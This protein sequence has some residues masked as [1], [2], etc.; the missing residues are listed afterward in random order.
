MN[1]ENLSV[2]IDGQAPE[3]PIEII[4]REGVA[5]EVVNP[6]GFSTIATIE[7]PNEYYQ[8]KKEK[9]D[10]DKAIITYSYENQQIT[11]HENPNMN[12]DVIVGKLKINPDLLAFGINQS[13]FN[14][15][16]LK[17]LILKKA[18]CFN[19]INEVKALKKKLENFSYKFQTEIDKVDDRKGNTKESIKNGLKFSDELPE[20]IELNTPLFVGGEPNRITLILEVDVDGTSPRFSFFCLELDNHIKESAKELIDN[21]LQEFAGIFPCLHEV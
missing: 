14:A 21:Q 1:I 11:F 17:Q 20:E 18:Y 9:R 8:R 13:G 5:I 15:S 3:E 2:S 16:Q 19:D 12:S 4:V 6:K 10:F 7:A